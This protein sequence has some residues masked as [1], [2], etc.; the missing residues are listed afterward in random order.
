MA[1]THRTDLQFGRHD[2]NLGGR[3]KQVTLRNVQFDGVLQVTDTS[4]LRDA[5]TQ[6]IGKGKAYGCGLMTLRRLSS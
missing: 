3:R 1:V 6:G 2:E 5:L 4:A